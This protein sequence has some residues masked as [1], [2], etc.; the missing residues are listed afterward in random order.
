MPTSAELRNNY[1]RFTRNYLTDLAIRI[2]DP[3]ESDEVFLRSYKRLTSLNSWQEFV[4]KRKASDEAYA[5]FIE[6]HN[7]AVSSHVLA[8][9]GSWRAALQSLRSCLENVF[10]C[11]YYKDHPVELRLW[12]DGKHRITFSEMVAYFKVHPDFFSLPAQFVDFSQI[13]REYSTLSRAVHASARS[14]RMTAS[15]T[16]TIIWEKDA[17]KLNMWDSRQREV[18]MLLNYFLLTSYRTEV[19]GA[20]L[21]GLRKAIGYSL[22]NE[23]HRTRVK[24]ILGVNI[25]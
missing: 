7:D 6:A 4:V 8:R 24:E 9:I 10:F 3:S 20:R 25:L 5:F 2:E 11:E 16:K 15:D 13:Q 23:D 17:A 19:N 14:F 12:C 1:Q 22:D 18:I 21:P